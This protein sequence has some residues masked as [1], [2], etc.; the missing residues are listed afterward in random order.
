MTIVEQLA[1]FSHRTRFAD[2]PPQVVHEAK[3]IVLDSLGCALAAVDEPKTVA[4]IQYARLIGAGSHEATVIGFPERLS[5][6]GAS[7]ANGEA[8]NALDMDAVLPPGHVTPYVVP[9][10]LA[11]AESVGLSGQDILTA[12]AIAHEIPNRIGKAM[13]YLRDV[14]DGVVDTPAVIGYSCSIF[15]AVA[16]IARLR[17]LPASTIADALGIAGN[18]SPVNSHRAWVEHTPSTTIKYLHAGALTQSSF[19]ASYMAE[20]GHRG[21]LQILNDAE[22]GYARFIGSKRWEKA[23]IVDRLGEVWGFPREMSYKPYPHC[24]ILHALLDALTEIVETN[25]IRPNE[26]DRIE[27]WVEGICERPIWW[28]RRIE[29]VQDAQFSIAHGVAVG[30][31]RVKPGKAWQDPSFVFSDSVM[32]LMNKV[33]HKVHPRY[34]EWL[35]SDPASRPAYVEVF[36]RGRSFAAE[37]RYPRGSNSVAEPGF[38]LSD[39]ELTAKFLHNADGV[40]AKSAAERIV[41][42][43]MDL[44]S[45]PDLR[46]LMRL[47]AALRAAPARAERVA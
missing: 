36:A 26:I 13:D 15:G 38:A 40:I 46:T 8:I 39:A 19:I 22:F 44:D 4:G 1:D 41:E 33:E 3:R 7:F 29:H 2:L 27:A 18:I 32:R 23:C 21:D 14:K 24:R 10:I 16:A 30:A 6:I 28:N 42:L 9:Q 31:H 34:V 47:T 11:V 37:R 5:S 35:V 17:R 12:T 20:F 43:V 25:D 45:V